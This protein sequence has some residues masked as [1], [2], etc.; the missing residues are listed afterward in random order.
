MQ[1]CT[2]SSE[3]YRLEFQRCSLYSVR[4]SGA[5]CDRTLADEVQPCPLR[6][7]AGGEG[8]RDTRR[9]AVARHLAKRIGEELG[10][11]GWRGG[12]KGI[13]CSLVSFFNLGRLCQYS[14]SQSLQ[15]FTEGGKSTTPLPSCIHREGGGSTPPPQLPKTGRGR[16][17]TPPPAAD[18]QIGVGPPPLPRSF[19]RSEGKAPPP[20]TPHLAANLFLGF[21]VT[22]SRSSISISSSNSSVFFLC[23]VSSMLYCA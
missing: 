10:E 12:R 5:H 7:G 13:V 14:H 22:R 9:R 2:L 6:S 11:E 23:L 21:G 20:L 19:Q 4:S 16:S 15:P 3:S 18:K 1:R 17:T 8:W